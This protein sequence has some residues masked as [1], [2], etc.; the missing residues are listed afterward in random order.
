MLHDRKPA[1]A[2]DNNNLRFWVYLAAFWILVFAATSFLRLT[3][4]HR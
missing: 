2:W 1:R 3:D 4:L